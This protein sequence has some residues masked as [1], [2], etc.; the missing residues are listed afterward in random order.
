MRQLS[1]IEPKEFLQ[2]P[3]SQA[4]RQV[5]ED[6][7]SLTKQGVVI[8]M[9]S[10]LST[11]E[12]KICSVCLGGAALCSFA[13]EKVNGYDI[14]TFSKEVL[15]LDIL[16]RNKILDTF[17]YLRSGHLAEAFRSWYK[18]SYSD[19]PDQI[20][21]LNTKYYYNYSNVLS[22]EKIKNLIKQLL[23]VAKSLEK[24]GY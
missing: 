13:P 6:V 2:L 23:K 1:Y 22:T 21:L 3:L 7:K 4:I 15:G 19:A 9:T 11:S 16:N 14:G 8:D 5:C 18:L 17:D 12:G 20:N 10:W 24:L